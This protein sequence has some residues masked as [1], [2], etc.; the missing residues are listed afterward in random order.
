MKNDSNEK[1]YYICPYCLGRFE[2]DNFW[3]QCDKVGKKYEKNHSI[4]LEKLGLDNNKAKKS[5]DDIRKKMF[6]DPEE[7][8]IRTLI[9]DDCDLGNFR[10]MG[11]TDG[12]TIPLG[13]NCFYCGK[14]AY[15]HICPNPACHH[16]IK[17][18]QNEK[19]YIVNL[20]GAPSSGKSVYLGALLFQIKNQLANMLGSVDWTIEMSPTADE[21]QKTFVNYLRGG[22]WQNTDVVQTEPIIVTFI[23]RDKNGDSM[24]KRYS[25]IFYDVAGELF[26]NDEHASIKIENAKQ[27]S[28]PDYL[29][30]LCDPTQMPNAC[31]DV[32]ESKNPKC[33]EKTK[34]FFE[35]DAHL[36]QS[37]RDAMPET[38]KV[39]SIMS[40]FIRGIIRMH[41]STIGGLVEADKILPTKVAAC[42]GMMDELYNVY[43]PEDE[44]KRKYLL[45]STYIDDYDFHAF[46]KNLESKSVNLRKQLGQW[47][48]TAFLA[49][50]EN[51]YKTSVYIGLSAL[52]T[53]PANLKDI[54]HLDTDFKP[55]NVL[56]PFIWIIS[57][58]DES[59]EILKDVK[60]VDRD[61]FNF[62]DDEDVASAS[63]DDDFS[64]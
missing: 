33:S 58:D 24:S 51:N 55:I 12:K 64:F 22:V 21:M 10:H 32:R 16:E 62:D 59:K 45:P 4:W 47:K 7:E 13:S 38:K 53:D 23:H 25:F 50:I 31:R 36:S 18:N 5:L 28:Y 61:E 44:E 60:P 37:T 57:Q 11:K 52:G 26:T 14:L 48:E 17:I 43:L 15:T 35:G 29:I 6:Y 41:S 40:K 8:D 30:M 27:F 34:A 3:F 42:L 56:D 46:F 49:E 19:Q 9:M 20:A 2:Y 1:K 39:A 54:K 63:A